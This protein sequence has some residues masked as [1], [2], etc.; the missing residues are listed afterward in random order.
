MRSKAKPAL[1][2]TENRRICG[3]GQDLQ[4]HLR[5]PPA[6][7]QGKAPEE[8]REAETLI[9]RLTMTMKERIET[10]AFGAILIVGLPALMFASQWLAR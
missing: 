7:D 2:R 5:R 10:A 4:R 8:C 6:Y 3:P 9:W 1:I